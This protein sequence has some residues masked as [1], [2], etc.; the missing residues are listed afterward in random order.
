MSGIKNENRK[1]NFVH[2]KRTVGFRRCLRDELQPVETCSKAIGGQRNW[3]AKN[4]FL[5]QT[6][7]SKR[8]LLYKRKASLIPVYQELLCDLIPYFTI[9]RNI[10]T[11]AT[12]DIRMAIG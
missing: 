8:S 2:P 7:A 9:D 4:R 6:R 10:I 3:I 12:S 1:N 5:G 11:I